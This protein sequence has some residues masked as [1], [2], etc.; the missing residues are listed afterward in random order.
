[1]TVAIVTR[2]LMDWAA[3]VHTLELVQ[4]AEANQAFIRLRPLDEVSNA[5][6]RV[7]L[8]DD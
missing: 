6:T 2:P 7:L 5:R 3:N 4:A 1:M 8:L